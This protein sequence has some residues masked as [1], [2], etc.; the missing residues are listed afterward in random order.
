MKKSRESKVESRT[1]ESAQQNA[2]PSILDPRPSTNCDAPYV[3]C[4]SP[5]PSTLNPQ[6]SAGFTLL[7]VMIAMAVFFIVVFAILGMVVQS[8]GAARALQIHRPDAGLVAAMVTMAAT[9]IEDGFSDSGDFSELGFPDYGWEWGATE[10]GTNFFRVDIAVIQ[11]DA[12]GKL[13]RDEMVIL[14]H[15]PPQPGRVRRLR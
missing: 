10:I 2:R 8:L 13:A 5:Q 1:P 15:N 7:E 14:K 9:N 11:K 6:P 3:L 4:G 12:K